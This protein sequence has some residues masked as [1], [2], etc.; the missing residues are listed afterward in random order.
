MREFFFTLLLFS[1]L[2]A[3]AISDQAD[4][5]ARSPWQKISTGFRYLRIEKNDS[6]RRKVNDSLLLNLELLLSEIREPG[7]V[8][9]TIPGL[10]R[11][12]SDD[13]R[14]AFF[15]W[16]IQWMTG[17]HQ[18]FGFLM[19]FNHKK[20]RKF[21]LTD[22]SATPDSADYRILDHPNWFGAL[23]NRIIT[24]ELPGGKRGYTLLG[25][26]GEDLL[27][28]RKVI[29]ILSFSPDGLPIFGL[30]IFTIPEQ[31][32][33]TRIIYRY[34]AQT[35]MVLKYGKQV[36]SSTLRWNPGRRRFD[37]KEVI[38][39]MIITADRLVPMDPLMEGQF[40]F[41]VPEG[42]ISDGFSFRDHRWVQIRDVESR[43]EKSRK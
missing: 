26:S 25:W 35:S 29:D 28:S 7:A 14:V 5:S 11:V 12:V 32:G 17:R 15:V 40:R 3:F 24:I 36:V 8:P 6:L 9:D 23:Y 22:I 30:D 33:L 34:S 41:Y 16:N 37:E 1:G 39:G 10:A 27:V 20:A 42:T 38:R 4:G 43:N 21:K 19:H 31:Q 2:S 18:Y 13:H